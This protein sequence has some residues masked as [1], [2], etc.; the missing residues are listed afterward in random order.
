MKLLVVPESSERCTGVIVVLGSL[1]PGLS[2]AIAG[3]FHFVIL[4]LKMSAI[5]GAESWSLST[6]SRLKTT[7]IG[8]TY[9]GTSIARLAAAALRGLR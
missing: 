2:A 6:P 7:A 4:P 1:A 9:A 3:S 5:V 8:L